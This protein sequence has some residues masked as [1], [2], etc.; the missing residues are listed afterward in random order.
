MQSLLTCNWPQYVRCGKDDQDGGGRDDGDGGDSSGGGSTPPPVPVGPELS[1]AF[2]AGQQVQ[3]SQ[4]LTVLA[5]PVAGSTS[6]MA[7][8]QQP[9]SACPAGTC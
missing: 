5:C 7:C 6:G 8:R 4:T 1:C 2:D 3:L 9:A